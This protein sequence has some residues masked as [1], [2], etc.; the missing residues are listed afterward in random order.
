MK[1]S[2]IGTVLGI[3]AF[4]IAVIIY[5]NTKWHSI[6]YYFQNQKNQQSVILESSS[7]DIISTLSKVY[8]ENGYKIAYTQEMTLGDSRKRIILIKIRI[9]IKKNETTTLLFD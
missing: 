1:E 2:I 8:L 4:F 5:E 6:K 7:F 9:S 3:V